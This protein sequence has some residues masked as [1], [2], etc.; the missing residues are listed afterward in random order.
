[1]SSEATGPEEKTGTWW[2]SLPG[3]VTA[4][5][6]L[7]T[8]ITGLVVALNQVGLFPHRAD[9]AQPNPE[10]HSSA[11]RNASEQAPAA[12]SGTVAS[13]GHE[14]GETAKV[15]GGTVRVL[16]VRRTGDGGS[17]VDVYYSVTVGPE[18]VRHDPAR[19]VRLVAGGTPI[20]PVWESAP[21]RDLA[22]TSSTAFAVKFQAP[23]GLGQEVVLRF[24]VAHPVDLTTKV[25]K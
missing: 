12:S 23:P 13:P 20:A 3:V 21:A 8:A 15:D 16:G 2:T 19:F 24:G 7:L 11:T 5:A 22:A 17:L 10:A 25:T 4:L 6:T 14:A 1:M 18:N 9:R